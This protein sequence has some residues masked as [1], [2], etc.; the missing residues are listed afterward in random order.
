MDIFAV[1]TW[2]F[3]HPN[4]SRQEFIRKN[5]YGRDTPPDASLAVNKFS[6]FSRWTPIFYRQPVYYG[7]PT[8]ITKPYLFTSNHFAFSSAMSVSASSLKTVEALLKVAILP[9]ESEKPMEAVKAQLNNLL[10][11]YSEDFGG[12][13]VIYHDIKCPPRKEFGRIMNDSYWL[14]IDIFVKVV[15]FQPKVG[16][17]VIGQINKVRV[18]ASAIMLLK[19]EV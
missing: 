8:S 1:T 4:F 3:I 11:R 18:K 14:H 13:P 16:N 19:L 12:V 9:S 17:A 6:V 10:F 7:T 15:L 5:I 2:T